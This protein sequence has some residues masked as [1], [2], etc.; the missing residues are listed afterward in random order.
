MRTSRRRQ[1]NATRCS[2]LTL[3]D[4]TYISKLKHIIPHLLSNSVAVVGE[5]G[6]VKTPE[7]FITGFATSR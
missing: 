4:G 3:H 1:N 6:A 2:S 7:H 5:A